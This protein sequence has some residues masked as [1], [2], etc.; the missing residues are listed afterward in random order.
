MSIFYERFQALKFYDRVQALKSDPCEATVR[1]I[2]YRV[3]GDVEF[4][5]GDKV[6]VALPGDKSTYVVFNEKDMDPNTVSV[7]GGVLEFSV[8]RGADTILYYGDGKAH[9]FKLDPSVERS[10]YL[11]QDKNKIVFFDEQS[12]DGEG[13]AEASANNLGDP[14]CWAWVIVGPWKYTSGCCNS[15]HSHKGWGLVG[16]NQE[17]SLRECCPDLHDL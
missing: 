6:S 1:G 15:D 17:W 4:L 8:N 14:K 5:P 13:C 11:D 16:C 2:S 9:H 12:C 3:S 10:F 7:L